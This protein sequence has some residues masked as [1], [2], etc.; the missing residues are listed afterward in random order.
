MGSTQLANAADGVCGK[1]EALMKQA[2][3]IDR[4]FRLFAAMLFPIALL[5]LGAKAI[6][7]G[8]SRSSSASRRSGN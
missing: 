5:G 2:Y 1:K 3:A 7:E 6:S 8:R 4:Q